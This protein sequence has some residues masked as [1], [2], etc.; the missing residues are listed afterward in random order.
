VR[1]SVKT[2]AT[3]DQSK[4]DRRNKAKLL[5]KQKREKLLEASRK[6]AGA[7]GLPKVISIVPLCPDVSCS[8]FMKRFIDLEFVETTENKMIYRFSNFKNQKIQIITNDERDILKVVQS[9]QIADYVIF[10]LSTEV[11]V[12]ENGELLIKLIKNHSVP[13]VV[14]V[15]VHMEQT[16]GQKQKIEIKKSLSSFMKHHFG[17]DCLLMG[18]KVTCIDERSEVSLMVRYLVTSV[19]KPVHWRDKRPYLV[20]DHIEY[21]NGKMLV[22]GYARGDIAFSP[23]RL[24]HL[25]GFGTFQVDKMIIHGQ[26][27]FLHDENRESLVSE[28]IPDMMENEQTWPTE[29]EL[30]EGDARI[31]NILGD[32]DVDGS[33]KK[34]IVV[35]KGFSSYQ[36]AWI[37]DSDE[38]EEE[39]SE[40][41]EM[42]HEAGL[43]TIEEEV[44]EDESDEEYEEI[45]AEEERDILEDEYDEEEERDQYQDYLEKK[46][47]EH[48]SN[49]EFPDEIDTPQNE[50]AR[51]RFQRYR[52]LQSFKTSPWDPYENLPLDYGKIFRFENM[53]HSARNAYRDASSTLTEAKNKRISLIIDNVPA[54]VYQYYNKENMFCLVHGLL[55]HEQKMSVAHFTVTRTDEF[56]SEPIKSKEEL[57]IYTGL[58]FLNIQPVF[59]QYSRGH[60]HKYERFLPVGTTTVGSIYAPIQ[61]SPAPILLFKRVGN[62]LKYVGYGGLLCN[63]PN[64]MMIKRIILTGHPFKINK[65]SAVIR[66]MFFNPQDIHWFK[67][68]QL[69]TKYGRRGH[70]RDSIG[71]HGYMKC[72]FDKPIQGH[73]TVCMN[74]Y[75]R[76][77]PKWTTMNA[78]E[79]NVNERK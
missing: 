37:V 49:L 10:L 11:E 16:E 40:V 21:D 14:P 35:P 50:P 15:A 55:R 66:Y 3:A 76:I 48:K 1:T 13:M 4:Q 34:K 42:D 28:N 25:T 7:N 73:D 39:R 77:Y 23:N 78:F 43:E 47:K 41:S 58:K 70:I 53:M 68:V 36:A 27:E 61:Y 44:H 45:E 17:E 30:A 32:M 19:P 29:E 79:S 8:E 56:Y 59:S 5:Q 51:I 9:T 33:A 65:K 52:G 24:I 71:T 26:T 18:D 54:N 67:P 75:K 72:I 22:S 57:Y 62:D 60:L 2:K 64:R 69:V 63:E 74:L 38:E 12:D 31:Q 20:A 46:Q 6:F